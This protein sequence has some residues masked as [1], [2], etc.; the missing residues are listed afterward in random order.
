MQE[1]VF[2]FECRIVPYLGDS[3]SVW[4]FLDRGLHTC[5]PQEQQ[6]YHTQNTPNYSSG[7]SC[8]QTG[9]IQREYMYHWSC[10]QR[11]FKVCRKT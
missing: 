6:A 4:D 2:I 10:A 3:D 9:L 1:I 11:G 5:V 8:L 7:V